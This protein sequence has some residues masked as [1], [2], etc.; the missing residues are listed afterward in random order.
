MS[1]Q[2]DSS[3]CNASKRDQREAEMTEKARACHMF[4]S[5]QT[6]HIASLLFVGYESVQYFLWRGACDRVCS[7]T[8][9]VLLWRWQWS[10]KFMWKD[11]PQLTNSS[12]R[13]EMWAERM[14]TLTRSCVDVCISNFE[15]LNSCVS[16]FRHMLNMIRWLRSI[17]HTMSPRCCFK[18]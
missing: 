17:W 3:Q 9:D 5:Y 12:A 16:R 7:P 4:A 2:W 8:S 6:S 10:V 14:H 11:L 15:Y 18:A 13:L 1:V